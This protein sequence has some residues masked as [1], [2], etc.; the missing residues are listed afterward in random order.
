MSIPPVAKI[1]SAQLRL[2][3]QAELDTYLGSRV[4][5]LN[6][7][8]PDLAPFGAALVDLLSGGKRLRPMFFYW[9]WRAAGGADSPQIMQAAASLELV[10]A[11]ALIH[12]DVM[13]R[14]DTRR[15]SPTAHRRFA[16]LHD[17]AGWPGPGDNFGTGA[18]ILLGDLSLSWADEMLFTSGLDQDDLL[19]AKPVFDE[20]RLE[21]M[22]GQYL[23]LVEQARGGG[24]LERALRVVQYK[25][26]KYTIERPLHLGAAL[27]GA[28][29]TL[30][31]AL[32]AFGLPLGTAFQLR[33]DLLGVFGDPAIT[34]K[35]AGDDLRE[36]KRTYLVA[37]AVESANPAQ[38][39]MIDT[40]LGNP[41][42]TPDAVTELRQ[43]LIDTGAVAAVEA[44]IS[45]LTAQA[46]GAL[47]A[48]Q[49]DSDARMALAELA[50]AATTRNG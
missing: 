41:N 16:A 44:Q 49:I 31:L 2:R 30:L 3:V 39:R 48:A 9:G 19:R 34:G 35:P 46:Q 4:P 17:A 25:S 14:S 10:Q 45:D 27:A 5:R 11:C 42:L 23:D 18:A 7:I 20:M 8:A 28:P 37:L 15:G 40:A 29:A 22:A 50:V 13:D 6:Q 32:S 47:A 26:A 1:D 24:S 43:I 33:D 36:G 12:D 21:I 38:T